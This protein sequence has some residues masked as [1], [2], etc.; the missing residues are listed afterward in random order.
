MFPPL[1]ESFSILRGDDH[2]KSLDAVLAADGWLQRDVAGEADAASARRAPLSQPTSPIIKVNY[3][4]ATR[5]VRKNACKSSSASSARTNRRPP[6]RSYF[7]ELSSGKRW[8]RRSGHEVAV[9][10]SAIQ[11]ADPEIFHVG[12]NQDLHHGRARSAMP[13]RRAVGRGVGERDGED[14]FRAR[15]G[16]QRSGAQSGAAAADLRSD[17]RAQ[18]PRCRP[19]SLRPDGDARKGS[20]QASEEAA[21]AYPQS[22]SRGILGMAT[23]AELDAVLPILQNAERYRTWEN[24]FKGTAKPGDWKSP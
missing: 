16:S 18:R 12:S 24:Q 10:V 23:S 20:P 8:W 5:K 11:V 15:G 6:P 21:A 13:E 4:A 1:I 7:L 17:R 2:A 9:Y 3:S 14:R 22:V 19:D